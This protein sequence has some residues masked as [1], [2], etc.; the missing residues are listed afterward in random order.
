[1]RTIGIAALAIVIAGCAVCGSV[2]G[3]EKVAA[4]RDRYAKSV[5]GKSPE[6]T[7]SSY[8][9]TTNIVSL[10]NDL[11][12]QGKVSNPAAQTIAKA[13]VAQYEVIRGDV[14][15]IK[16]PSGDYTL[17]G[18]GAIRIDSLVIEPGRTLTIN[19][20][21]ALTPVQMTT[22]PSGNIYGGI[23]LHSQ[24]PGSATISGAGST[25]VSS[26]SSGI[27]LMA[28]GVLPIPPEE[29]ARYQAALNTGTGATGSTVTATKTEAPAIKDKKEAHRAARERLI[30]LRREK[31]RAAMKEVL[32]SKSLIE[33]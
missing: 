31:Q 27:Q 1:M 28:T 8:A 22:T 26:S 11:I 16:E 5:A 6:D 10:Q 29:I 30:Q 9:A 18:S 32:D 15:L 25:L 24:T 14:S 20:G 21:V 4:D 13:S 7:Q 33:K 19:A 12:A 2:N 17:T 23:A 3:E